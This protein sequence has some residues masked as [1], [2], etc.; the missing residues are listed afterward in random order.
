MKMVLDSN[1]SF[2]CSGFSVWVGGG[3]G[4]IAILFLSHFSLNTGQSWF[5]AEE[6]LNHEV[7]QFAKIDMYSSILSMI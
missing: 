6:E 3:M 2:P 7:T 1:V 5:T 4:F